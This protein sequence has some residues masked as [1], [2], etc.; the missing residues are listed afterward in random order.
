MAAEA[1]LTFGVTVSLSATTATGRVAVNLPAAQQLVLTNLGPDLIYVK[2]GDVTV[3]AV[4]ANDFP[5]LPG[6]QL[7]VS[8]PAGTIYV[9]GIT[10]TSTATL[11]VT[12]ADGYLAGLGGGV[13]GSTGENVTIVGPLGAQAATASVAVIT[14][15]GLTASVSQTRPTNTTAYGNND[16]L[17][18]GSGASAAAAAMDF[19]LGA[20]SASKIMITSASLEIDVA[21][22]PSGATNFL[23]YLYNV[24][25]PSALL[26]N[27]PFD[28]PSGDRASFL[29]VFNLGTPVDLGST[30]YVEANGINKQVVLAG[31]HIFGYLVTVTAYT[32]T[33]GSVLKVTLSAMQ[34]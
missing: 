1:P 16:I 23:L 19:N 34:V 26:D 20:V 25:P 22:L 31:T 32:P 29:G 28:L 2:I 17:G 21:S 27:D 14:T 15:P 3:T 11:K 10:P 13:A 9:A 7:A 6:T 12:S 8:A 5:V 24:T 18:T 4:V 33:S 30:L